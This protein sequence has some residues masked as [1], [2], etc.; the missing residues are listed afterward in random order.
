MLRGLYTAAFGM[1][2]N[3]AKQDVSAN[4]IANSTTPGYKQDKVVS[5]SFPEVMLQNK[6][7]TEGGR[8]K[9]SVIGS[10]PLGVETDEI[11][12][13]FNQGTFQDTGSDFD[14]AISGRGLF[15][16]QHFDGITG[17]TMF[18]R[19]GNF[20]LDSDGMLVTSEGDHVLG[21]DA[22]TGQVGPMKIG[23]GKVDV[24]SQGSLFV[25]SQKKYNIQV[26]DFDDY[27]SIEKLGNNMYGI[28]DNNAVPRTLNADEYNLKQGS[29]EVSNVDMTQEIV[30]MMSTL[31]SYQANQR[32]LQSIDE[33]LGKAVNEVGAV[34]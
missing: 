4:N 15:A 16:V 27:N 10:L 1:I 28:K 9:N 7:N 31:R 18:T 22:S 13:D 17:S 30:G 20:K 24:D 8:P 33:T 3:Q 11:Y 23:N 21:T 6:D 32:V 29:L 14:F 26:V 5:K 34:K 2:N 12:T 19:N 25:D